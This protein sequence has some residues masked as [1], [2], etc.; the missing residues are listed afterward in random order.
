[1]GKLSCLFVYLTLLDEVLIME[2]KDGRTGFAAH[3]AS[4]SI[5]LGREGD[6]SPPSSAE[7]KNAYSP[8]AF[9]VCTGTTL[10][11]NLLAI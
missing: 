11:E 10:L 1:M 6:H 8:H 3:P 4:R 9:T 5:G 7:V 2:I